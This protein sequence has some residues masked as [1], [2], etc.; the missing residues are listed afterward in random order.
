MFFVLIKK[1]KAQKCPN[2]KKTD[3][4]IPLV[5]YCCNSPSPRKIKEAKEGKLKLKLGSPSIENVYC[6]RCG[7]SFEGIRKK[8]EKRQVYL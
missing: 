4:I 8:K 1:M 7:N 6:K 2:C 3:S 5:Y